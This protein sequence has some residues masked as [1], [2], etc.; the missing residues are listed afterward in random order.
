MLALCVLCSLSR[1][2]SVLCIALF[3][4]ERLFEEM[5]GRV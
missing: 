4:G 2:L 3:D 1:S 5:K